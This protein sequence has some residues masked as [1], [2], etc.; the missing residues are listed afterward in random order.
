MPLQHEVGVVLFGLPEAETA[1][2]LNEA[3]NS[4]YLGVKEYCL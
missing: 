2:Q 3:E 4:D 1:N